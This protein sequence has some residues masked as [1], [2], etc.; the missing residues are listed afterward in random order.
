MA[1]V[2]PI[3]DGAPFEEHVVHGEVVQCARCD[4]ITRT[5]LTPYRAGTRAERLH[6]DRPDA[7]EHVCL[8]CYCTDTGADL[9][10][11]TL[12]E[13]TA[14]VK[15]IAQAFNLLYWKGR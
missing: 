15:A 2:I 12:G 1:D 3:I 7:K 8:F 4:S 6:R 14:A 10:Y 11:R 9:A 13:Q 5:T